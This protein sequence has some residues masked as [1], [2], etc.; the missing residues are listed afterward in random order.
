MEVGL[1]RLG[2]AALFAWAYLEVRSGTN[3]F[4]RILGLVVAFMTIRT[5]FV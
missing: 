4:R 5:F 3:T 2:S 1:S